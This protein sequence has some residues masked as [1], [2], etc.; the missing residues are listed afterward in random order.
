MTE[1][2]ILIGLLGKTLNKSA[3]EVATLI[4]ETEKVDDK[5]VIKANALDNLLVE[6]RNRIAKHVDE[7]KTYFDNGYKKAQGESLG[8]F[9]K[10]VKEKHGYTGNEQ[11]VELF[12]AILANKIKTT[13]GG[14][15]DDEKIKRSKL[16][17]DTVQKLTKE[18]DDAVKAEQKKVTDLE[19][20][21]KREK[22]FSTVADKVRARIKE[23]NPIL[24]EGKTPDGKLKADIQVDRLL[25]ELSLKY[26]FDIKDDGKILISTKDGKLVE[27]PQHHPVDL[28]DLVKER[29]TS[30]WDFKQ[31]EQRQG[32]D[33]NNDDQGGQ[34][35]AKGYKGAIP[36]NDE[37]YNKILGELKDE[38]QKVELTTLYTASTKGK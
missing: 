24:P 15:L 2:E 5:E 20:A 13:T 27:T 6:D 33:N 1:K 23:L 12:D 10:D 38:A 8:K 9:E 16:Y 26:D 31:G 17:Q 25:E 11:G 19:T 35:S 28:G 22:T 3:E 21:T 14:E 18:K 30:Y 29:A 4:Y 36:K 7:K 37:E 34:G 32:T